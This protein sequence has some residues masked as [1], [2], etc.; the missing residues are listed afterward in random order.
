M[1]VRTQIQLTNEQ[2]TALKRL[3]ALEGVSMAELIRRGVDMVLVSSQRAELS[4]RKR[5]AMK[6]AGQFKSGL[7]DLSTHHDKYLAEDFKA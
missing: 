5:Q 3:A 7:S 1:M 6:V 2:V 4:E